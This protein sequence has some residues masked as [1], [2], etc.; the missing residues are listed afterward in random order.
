LIRRV[1]IFEKIGEFAHVISNFPPDH[2]LFTAFRQRI[3][4]F[5]ICDEGDTDENN[6]DAVMMCELHDVSRKIKK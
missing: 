2:T 4:Y 6:E 1:N 3:R 5:K